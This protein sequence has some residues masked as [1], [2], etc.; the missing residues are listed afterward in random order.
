MK[1][2]MSIPITNVPL[3]LLLFPL[4]TSGFRAEWCHRHGDLRR[5]PPLEFLAEAGCVAAGCCR[6]LLPHP[7]GIL[8]PRTPRRATQVGAHG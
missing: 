7:S 6:L 1:N 5:L 3:L 8:C 2:T 4:E